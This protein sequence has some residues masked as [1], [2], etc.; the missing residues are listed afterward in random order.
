MAGIGSIGGGMS[1]MGANPLNGMAG[2]SSGLGGSLSGMGDL[3]LGSDRSSGGG[4]NGSALGI[5]PVQPASQAQGVSFGETL[6]S[7]VLDKPSA[8][9]RYSSE[10][11]MRFASGDTSIDPHQ[12]SIASAKAGVEIQMAT[13][14]I[15]ST[16]SAVRTLF[17]MQV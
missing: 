9:K 2:G 1:G 13:R 5:A 17:Q 7:M 10:L 11:A 16:V 12:M 4:G 8:S 15:S 14:T 6:K 3:G